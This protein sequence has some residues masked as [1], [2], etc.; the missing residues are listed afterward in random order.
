[1]LGAMASG[2]LERIFAA[3]EAAGARYLVV[4]GV[5]VVLHG[6]PRFT[7]DLD[8]V[9]ALEPENVRAALRALRGLGYEPRAPVDPE[10][11]ADPATREDWVRSKGLTV[12]SF[13]SRE[14]STTEVHVFVEEPFPFEEAYARALRAELGGLRVC[15]ASIPD[16]VA[17][18]Y[19]TGCPR[20]VED[21]RELEAIAEQSEPADP[22]RD[23]WDA[24][25]TRARRR[26]WLALGHRERLLWLE[27][28]KR[29]AERALSA[30]DARR[31]RRPREEVSRRGCS[32]AP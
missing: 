16:L 5:A 27:E 32:G 17:T 11:L 31:R 13:A 30:A 10:G 12:F 18:K 22:D 8:L 7:A 9:L 15:V 25:Q 28:A 29:F 1:M 21:A 2:S 24:H 20:D 6:H 26:A 4:G 19:R 14:T 3:L 23:S